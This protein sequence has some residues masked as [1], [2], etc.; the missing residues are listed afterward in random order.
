MIDKNTNQRVRLPI[1]SEAVLEPGGTWYRFDADLSPALHATFNKAL[2]SKVGSDRTWSYTHTK[3][4][5]TTYVQGGEKVRVSTDET[6]RSVLATIKKVRLGDLAIHMPLHP[7]DIR[8]SI[9][10]ELPVTGV[11]SGLPQS[12]RSK[13]RR[14]Y[15]NTRTGL[16]Y[17]LTE[18]LQDN[19]GQGAVRK[20]EL[21]LEATKTTN[22]IQ[23]P[24]MLVNELR[25]FIRVLL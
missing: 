20:F 3:T 15:L 11:V 18:V 10:L 17:D 21:E 4:V 9:N 22:I 16:Q 24:A 1:V 6:G 12:S 7:L 19:K 14:S 23:D 8:I 2:N 5:D 13:D 25:S